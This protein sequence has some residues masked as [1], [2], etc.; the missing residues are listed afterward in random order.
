MHT[1]MAKLNELLSKNKELQETLANDNFVTETDFVSELKELEADSIR[2]DLK[3]DKFKVDK[4]ELLESIVE[5]E[6][7]LMLWERKIQLEKETQAALDPTVGESEA[8]G[9]EREIHRMKLR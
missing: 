2:M 3:V 8:Q 7:Q 1:D 6:R 9:M 4:A 5:S